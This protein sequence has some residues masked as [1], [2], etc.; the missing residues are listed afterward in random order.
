MRTVLALTVLMSLSQTTAA[1]RGALNCSDLQGDAISV[2]QPVS[3]PTRWHDEGL[4]Y[5]RLLLLLADEGDAAGDD[6]GDPM[7]TR[8]KIEALHTTDPGLLAFGLAALITDEYRAS[9]REAAW[10]A[11]EFL[12]LQASPTLILTRLPYMTDPWRRM[13]AL[14][15]L[16]TTMSTQEQSAVAGALCDTALWLIG[17]R[18]ASRSTFTSLTRTQAAMEE[19]LFVAYAVL[20]GPLRSSVRPMVL[21]AG[22]VGTCQRLAHLDGAP[23][24]VCTDEQ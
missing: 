6:R 5:M 18:G 3:P 12:R 8:G 10:A 16:S 9:G 20:G 14:R 23:V 1:Q 15:A 13:Q 24:S 19:F 22:P 17:L 21:L 11:D 2:L 7:A 4:S